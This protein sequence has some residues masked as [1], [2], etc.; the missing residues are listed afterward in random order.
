MQFI[1]VALGN[2]EPIEKQK[3]GSLFIWESS[4]DSNAVDM[5][6]YGP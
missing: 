5:A 4:H 3:M 6:A 2:E 1:K